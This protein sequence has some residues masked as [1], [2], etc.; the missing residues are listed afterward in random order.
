MHAIAYARSATS[1][2]DAI[3]RQLARID[4][5]VAGSGGRVVA[6]FTDNGE[7]G[8]AFH[9]RP[10]LRALLGWV[11]AH[12]GQAETVVVTDVSRLG[13]DRGGV[14]DL[15]EDLRTRGLTVV[16]ATG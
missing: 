15:L 12:P 11:A 7:S 9:D 6:T 13:R 5:H 8:L 10:S 14:H 3:Q 1:D 16:E 2:A 4:A